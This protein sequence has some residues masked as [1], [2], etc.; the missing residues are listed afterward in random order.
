MAVSLEMILTEDEIAQRILRICRGIRI[1]TSTD[2]VNEIMEEGPG[3][4]FIAHK[5]TMR[6]FRDKDEIYT[7]DYFPSKLRGTINEKSE[8]IEIANKLVRDILEGPIDDELPKDVVDTMDS[9][10][11]EAD[12]MATSVVATR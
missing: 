4:T 7:S 3:G 8:A 1:D 5:S 11:F 10:C 12:L 2:L 6:N 9:I